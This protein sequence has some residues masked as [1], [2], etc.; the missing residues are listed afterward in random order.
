VKL[1]IFRRWRFDRIVDSLWRLSE[2]E[3]GVILDVGA[4]AAQG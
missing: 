2:Q 4:A 3:T 1:P